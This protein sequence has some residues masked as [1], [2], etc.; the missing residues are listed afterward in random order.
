MRIRKH[1]RALFGVVL[2]LGITFTLTTEVLSASRRRS[3]PKAAQSSAAKPANFKAACTAP[4]FPSPPP[5]AKLD[6]DTLCGVA[7]SGTGA[8]AQ[9]NMA[10]NNFCATGAP[11]PITIA[12][13]K[14][15]QA[16]VEKNKSINFGDENTATTK[17]GPTTNRAPL[18]KLGEGR[19]V[20]L[21][22]YVLIARQEGG[23]SVNCGKNVPNH[24]GFH[25]IHISLVE[26]KEAPPEGECAGVVAEMSPHRR[27]DS[28]SH[29]SVSKVASAQLPVRVTGHLYFDSSHFPCS[30]G[31]GVRSNPRRASLWEIHPIYKFEVCTSANCADASATWLSLDQWVTQQ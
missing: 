7:G 11:K 3:K 31:Q 19:L 2:L 22:A 30:N 13:L 16:Q 12:D 5:K 27:P 8:E 14:N 20:T 23:E 28:W 29:T 24:P 4:S 26:T 1:P 21:Q 25:D 10:K 15:L 9:Q 18:R 17:K 6:I